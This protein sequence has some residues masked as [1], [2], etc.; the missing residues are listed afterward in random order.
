MEIWNRKMASYLKFAEDAA[1]SNASVL[2]LP[3]ERV[4]VQ[5]T[6]A[7]DDLAT[8]LD[9][10]KGTVAFPTTS[11]KETGKTAKDYASYY[12]KQL[13]RENIADDDW[14]FIKD[15]I[16]WKVAEQLGYAP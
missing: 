13:W 16:D 9:L 12:G 3:S 5:P 15:A 2:F 10:P 7:A 4:T 8:F 1:G 11:T 14:A 6:E